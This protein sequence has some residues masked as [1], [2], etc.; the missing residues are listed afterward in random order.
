MKRTY[1]E[2]LNHIAYCDKVVEHIIDADYLE[3]FDVYSKAENEGYITIIPPVYCDSAILTLKM[4]I[5]KKPKVIT[6]SD[7]FIKSYFDIDF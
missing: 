7:E 1:S 5:L 2:L 4:V 6:L 3:N